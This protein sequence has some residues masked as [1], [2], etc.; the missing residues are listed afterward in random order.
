MPKARDL[1]LVN[2]AEEGEAPC[3]SA[4]LP[5]VGAGAVDVP[6]LPAVPLF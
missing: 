5:D 4:L 6:V 2:V 1:G 3:D